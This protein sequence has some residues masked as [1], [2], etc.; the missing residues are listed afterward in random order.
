MIQVPAETPVTR[1]VASTVAIAVLLLLQVPPIVASFKLLVAPTQALGVPVMAAGAV[2][3]DTTVDARVPQPVVY[4]MVTLPVATPVTTPVVDTTVAIPLLVLLQVPPDAASVSVMVD[5]EQ[6]GA[7][8][9]MADGADLTVIAVVV[10]LV[11][12]PVVLQV[13]LPVQVITQ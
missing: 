8:P 9:L 13:P 5:P 2:L 3:T 1:P 6:S 7:L 12:V 4:L 11:R 10:A